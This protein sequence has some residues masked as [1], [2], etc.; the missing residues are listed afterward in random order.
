VNRQ[1]LIL[2]FVGGMAVGSAQAPEQSALAF[3][4]A[5]V[6]RNASGSSGGG[7]GLQPSG[8]AATNVLLRTMIVHAYQ[9]KRF[10]IIGGPNW[11]DAERFDAQ[12]RAAQD[13]TED[14]LFAM[15]RTLL[16][17]RFKLVVHKEVREQPVYALVKSQVDGK[18]GGRLKPST[19]D[20]S[21]RQLVAGSV[22]PTIEPLPPRSNPCGIYVT[23][24]G[25]RGGA[26]TTRA[27]TIADLASAL[28]ST[29]DR[30]VVDRI[31]LQGTYEFDL[32]WGADDARI[33][34]GTAGTAASDT[35]SLF[36]ALQEQLGLKLESTRGPVD[37]LVIDSVERPTPD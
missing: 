28:G 8:Y 7:V 23:S 32:T 17:Q 35:P 31:G 13:A 4:V 29:L 15:V 25:D 12:A 37:V 6:K 30:S 5:S 19:V 33:T 10:Q 26:V 22:A 9:L 36:T 34:P 1:V 16:A 18:L 24:F 11:I 20:C 2:A 27:K 3:E 14:Q 21:P